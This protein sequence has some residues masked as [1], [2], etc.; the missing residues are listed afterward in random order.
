LPLTPFGLSFDHPGVEDPRARAFYVAYAVLLFGVFA[1]FMSAS[2][3]SPVSR[4][5]LTR[6]VVERGVLDVD[7]W[8]EAT[9]DRAQ[10]GGHWYTD[11]APVPSFLAMPAY[12]VDHTVDSLRGISP[13]FVSLSTPNMP[14]RRVTVN[15]SFARSLYVCSISTASLAGVAVGLLVLLWLRRRCSA[16]AAFAGSASVALA[17]PVFPYSTCFYGHVVAAAF[18]L[19]GFVLL[20]RSAPSRAAIRGAGLLLVL[21]SGSEYIVAL[22]AAVLV[23]ASLGRARAAAPRMALDLALGGVLPAVALGAYHAA[24]FGNPFTTGYAFLPRAEFAGGHS[25]GFFGVSLPRASAVVGL[26]VGPRRGLFLV[27]PV[28]A[29]GALGLGVRA[30]KGSFEERLA[31][32]LTM[33]LFVANAGYY[34]WWGGAAT[35]PRHLVPVLPFLALGVAWAWQHRWLRAIT[36]ALALVSFANMLAFT[37]VGVE[38]PEHGNSLIDYAWA[39]LVTGRIAHLSGASNLGVR[40]GLPRNLSLAPLVVWLILGLR[41]LVLGAVDREGGQLL[42]DGMS[43]KAS[44]ELVSPTDVSPIGADESSPSGDE[45][46][47]SV[48]KTRSSAA[49]ALN[50]VP[51]SASETSTSTPRGKRET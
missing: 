21:A 3:W 22:P 50:V 4:L 13:Q 45:A 19:G 31:A 47:S 23:V 20:T 48:P 27:A 38:A 40:L 28:A 37:A 6:A 8:A 33:V 7:P 17:T 14:A 1:Y 16:S 18:L 41:Y 24:C 36:F 9:G 32:L 34:M 42:V 11:K 51:A 26:L 44:C 15:D 29:V 46:S 30:V 2:T 39:G 25:Q 5:G 43:S 35:G 12:F 10:R 49:H